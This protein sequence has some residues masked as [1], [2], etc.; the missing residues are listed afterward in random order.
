[1]RVYYVSDF[2]ANSLS[3]KRLYILRFKNRFDTNAIYLYKSFK[4][5]LKTDYHENIYV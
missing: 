5:M 4:N 2:D 3:Y 1:M